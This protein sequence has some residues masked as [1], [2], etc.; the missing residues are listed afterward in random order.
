MALEHRDS[1]LFEELPT[2]AVGGA[3]GMEVGGGAGTGWGVA[4]RS[5]GAQNPGW[6]LNLCSRGVG[7]PAK[8]SKPG[9]ANL[10]AM[11]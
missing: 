8:G 1:R 7:K 11:V 6:G 3:C 5:W 2:R 4:A 10:T 9:M